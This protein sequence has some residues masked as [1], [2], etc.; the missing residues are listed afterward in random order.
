M[1]WAGK[2]ALIEAK[3]KYI[4]FFDPKSWKE[5]TTWKTDSQIRVRKYTQGVT[6]VWRICSVILPVVFIFACLINLCFALFC[7]SDLKSILLSHYV[8]K[9]NCFFSSISYLTEN[10]LSILQTEDISMN[11]SSCKMPVSIVDFNKFEFWQQILIKI[12][13]IKLHGS[14]SCRSW[15]VS[16]WSTCERTDRLPKLVADLLNFFLNVTNN[17]S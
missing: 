6:Q 1:K 11:R 8:Q 16:C 13:S 7:H 9:V 17:G 5:D 14:P 4:T 12:P 2:V 15:V 10:T 3:Q